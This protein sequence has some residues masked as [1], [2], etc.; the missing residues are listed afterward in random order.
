MSLT[1]KDFQDAAEEL[2]VDVAAIKAVAEVES[3]GD[4]FL[5]SGEPKILFERHKFHKYTNGKFSTPENRNISWPTPSK[6]GTGKINEYGAT[7]EQHARLAK[8]AALDRDAALQSA[9]WG[10]FQVMGFNWKSLEYPSLQSFIN[11]MYRSEADHLDAFLRYV[12]A[13]G[14]LGA[15][16][17]HRWAAFARGY[18]GKD[19]KINNYDTKLAAAYRKY[20]N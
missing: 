11:A 17:N 5:P 6:R 18:N 7:S 3:R 10:R 9:S 15:L 1:E 19:Y 13:N 4:G 12:K 14:L 8:A 2:S 20:S 16:R